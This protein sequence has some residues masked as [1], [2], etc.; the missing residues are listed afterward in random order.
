MNSFIGISEKI[1]PPFKSTSLLLRRS[2][3][4][5]NINRK[6]NLQ[7]I[8]L[9]I[10]IYYINGH[11][12]T[13]NVLCTPTSDYSKSVY[14]E[15]YDVSKYIK[16][17]KNVIAVELGNGF[18]NESLE[19]VWKFNLCHWRGDKCL[20][21]KLKADD[22]LILKSDDQFKVI[23]S[24]YILYNELRG[25]EILDQR[26]YIDFSSINFDDSKWEN[27][28]YVKKPPLGKIRKNICPPIKEFESCA[29]VR[30]IKNKN[31][32]VFDFGK[33]MS[34]YVKA[35]I[36]NN[37]NK[38]ITFRYAEDIS[39]DGELSLHGL[40]CY[41]KGEPFQT[42]V[43][44]A[45]GSHFSF[46]PRFTYHGFRYVELTGV[47]NLDDISLKAIF[48]HQDIKY[49]KPKKLTNE[50]YE[51][52]FEAG[53]NSILSNTYYGFT[54]C[55]TREKLNWLNDFTAS[56]P[57]IIKYFDC[58][59]MLIKIFQ[60]IIDSQD[61]K[62]NIPGIAPSPH[63]GYEYG[64]VCSG[65]FI[66][67]P[68]MFY[69][70]YG[71][72]SLFVNNISRIKKYYH[73]IKNNIDSGYFVLGDWTGTTN[74][75]KTPIRFV[76]DTYMYL[77]DKILYEMTGFNSYKKDLLLRTNRILSYEVVGQTIPSVLLVLGLGDKKKNLD[78][79]L[80]DIE[81]LDFH[82]DVGMFGFQYLF[83]ALSINKLDDVIFKIVCNKKAPSFQVWIDEGATTF[84]ETFGDTWSLSM[85]HHMF[86]N[87][88]L[89]LK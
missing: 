87:I 10:A 2:F 85:N 46:V 8:G 78:V 23:Y 14:Y 70:H 7:V 51:K 48:I 36:Y 39:K 55:P 33:N 30:V 32:Y 27:A 54:D 77:F 18:Y 57:V 38:E 76:L 81:A 56:L 86:S 21:L 29:P 16:Q 11:R 49:L 4:V 84:F 71:D 43:C 35:D 58:K 26:K 75:E 13:D 19:T 3:N 52:I 50:K 17:G 64:P 28:T 12:I 72:K 83:K 15:E 53:I 31:G 62:G 66:T 74:H 63:W 40:N 68:Y 79:L 45:D 41:Q 82:F 20:Y 42:D 61:E 80:K 5:R 73:F 25:G 24:L 69:K 34:G 65:I 6:F 89:Y 67:L 22:K 60:D 47:D 1:T 9:G 44:V 59:E 88:I 37:A